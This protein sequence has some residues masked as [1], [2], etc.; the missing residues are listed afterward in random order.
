M[1]DEI[2]EHYTYDGHRHHALA[3]LPEMRE[4]TVV[5]NS[6]SKTGNATGWRVGWVIAPEA[7]TARI[8]AVHDTLVVQAPTP[9]QKAAVSLLTMP[10]SYFETIAERS[11]AKREALLEALRRVG[12]RCAAPEGAYYVFADYRGVAALAGRTPTEAAIQLIEQVG[13]A[14]V[15]G[16]NFYATAAGADTTY[17]RFAFC[18]GLDSLEEAARRLDALGGEATIET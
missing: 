6:I 4:R 14:A 5:V 3:T 13:V 9:L 12:F 11:V 7:E 17:L 15:P 10:R 1:T 8:R 18:R 2:Y 16:D